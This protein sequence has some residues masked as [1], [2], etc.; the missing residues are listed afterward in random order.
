MRHSLLLVLALAA[1]C[2]RMPDAVD[3]ARVGVLAV[4]K[5]DGSVAAESVWGS[6]VVRVLGDSV[7]H[8]DA[9]AESLRAYLHVRPARDSDSIRH[10]LT[11]Y[12]VRGTGNALRLRFDVARTQR[13]GPTWASWFGFSGEYLAAA[14]RTTGDWQIDSVRPL[15]YGDPGICSSF[16]SRPPPNER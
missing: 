9:V 16:I 11:V 3:V 7:P 6:W 15:I 2:R 13:C 5:A 10:T 14:T 12:S 8:A 4:E 1:S